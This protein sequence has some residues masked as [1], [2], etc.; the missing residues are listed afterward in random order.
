MIPTSD[1]SNHKMLQRQPRTF[2]AT[3]MGI[4]VASG[5]AGP[6]VIRLHG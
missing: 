6:A 3:M 5:I 1:S 2:G 4:D